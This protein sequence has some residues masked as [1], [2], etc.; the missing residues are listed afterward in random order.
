MPKI[1]TILPIFIEKSGVGHPNVVSQ[2]T[3]DVNIAS[4]DYLRAVFISTLRLQIA[5]FD[6]LTQ[7][8]VV[9]I[10][11]SHTHF[12]IQFFDGKKLVYQSSCPD[13]SAMELYFLNSIIVVKFFVKR[14][15][16]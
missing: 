1:G 4:L 8:V 11:R 13:D 6:E 5:E 10:I 16:L 12:P 9:R 2:H 3:K 15:C 7:K 14:V